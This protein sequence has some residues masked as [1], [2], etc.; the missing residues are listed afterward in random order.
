MLIPAK[1]IDLAVQ[2]H[3]YGLKI[4]PRVEKPA[5]PLIPGSTT[6]CPTRS[7]PRPPVRF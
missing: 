5:Y 3:E 4:I 2:L 6:L 1:G 7:R